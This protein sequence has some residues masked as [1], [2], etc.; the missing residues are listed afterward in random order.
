[1]DRVLLAGSMEDESTISEE[2]LREAKEMIGVEMRTNDEGLRRRHSWNSTATTDTIRHFAKGYGDDNPLYTDPAYAKGTRWGALLAPPTWLFTVDT[3]MVAPKLPGLQWQHGRTRFE[4][5]R[6]VRAGD[7]FTVTARQTDVQKKVGETA[8]EMVQQDGE[9]EFVAGG[10][11]V[12]TAHTSMF[13]MDRQGGIDQHREPKRWTEVELEEIDERILEQSRR[14][15]EIRYWDTVAAGDKLEPRLKGPLSTT[16]ILCWYMGFG[17]PMY[18]G[19]ELAVRERVR[20]PGETIRRDDNGIYEHAGM[21][22]FDQDLAEAVGISRRYDI[23]S[24]RITWLGQ[25]VTDWMSDAG[26]VKMLD[27]SV[28]RL[29]FVGELTTC[30]GEVTETYVDGEIGEHLVDVELRATNHD[31]IETASGEATVRLPS[32]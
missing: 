16:D 25:V 18:H 13:R 24:Q 21:C 5:E 22:H 2:A 11:P 10:K 32:S 23:A 15:D 27:V 30:E 19:H 17:A 6:P 12:A 9:V 29:N 31:G 1:M 7:E 4:Y 20:H 26:F 3:T 28:K 8:G 14:G